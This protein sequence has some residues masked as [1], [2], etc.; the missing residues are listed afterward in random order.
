MN[1]G[2]V[3][4]SFLGCTENGGR[5]TDT[6]ISPSKSAWDPACVVF[7]DM[8]DCY[9]GVQHS[10]V[11]EV[12]V[13]EAA[14]V[15]STSPE[16]PSH[17]EYLALVTACNEVLLLEARGAA[18]EVGH[19][20]VRRTTRL[21][22]QGHMVQSL[23]ESEAYIAPR[24]LAHVTSVKERD[25][26]HQAEQLECSLLGCCAVASHPTIP[27]LF[28]TGGL[29]STAR[30][31][32]CS[33]AGMVAIYVV[34]SG[35]ETI[36]AP[37]LRSKYHSRSA[38]GEGAE[39]ERVTAVAWSGKERLEHHIAVGMQSGTVHI[40]AFTQGR[41]LLRRLQIL[42]PFPNYSQALSDP[43]TRKA[44]HHAVTA[45]AVASSQ[46]RLRDAILSLK[47]T[48]DGRMLAAGSAAGHVYIWSLSCA[49]NYS[50]GGQAIR[51]K[52]N[53]FG[54]PSDVQSYTSF[55]EAE[56]QPANPLERNADTCDRLAEAL[57]EEISE[58]K[59]ERGGSPTQAPSTYAEHVAVVAEHSISAIDWALFTDSYV[60]STYLRATTCNRHVI[61][62]QVSL[63][64][65]LSAAAGQ[66]DPELDS[67]SGRVTL[68]QVEAGSARVARLGDLRWETWTSPSGWTVQGLV[69]PTA[70]GVGSAG[71]GRRARPGGVDSGTRSSPAAGWAGLGAKSQQYKPGSQVVM[72]DCHGAGARDSMW[73]RD[74]AIA[75]D[76]DGTLRLARAPVLPGAQAWEARLVPELQWP[77][78]LRWH[79]GMAFSCDGRRVCVLLG[80]LVRVFALAPLGDVWHEDPAVRAQRRADMLVCDA[81]REVCVS[82]VRMGLWMARA[83]L[84]LHGCPS[85]MPQERGVSCMPRATSN[86]RIALWGWQAFWTV[87]AKQLQDMLRL[88]VSRDAIRLR[89]KLSPKGRVV[90]VV[91]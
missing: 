30:V 82:H 39:R 80:G 8:L 73:V 47:Y 36:G 74:L 65:S 44:V 32:D 6:S 58:E 22:T 17:V 28:V 1:S 83:K 41:R 87:S 52:S 15:A 53:P 76:S 69:A 21:L 51:Q 70:G 7:A 64:A 90:Q 18:G 49:S 79:A 35:D 50:L 29:D 25:V 43:A 88:G 59:L 63:D 60:S 77:E 11:S 14:S 4:S 46:W 24:K 31:W 91:K 19:G 13:V 67:G 26:P 54:E 84:N 66:D 37:K 75:A 45:Q 71:P 23:E 57:G 68:D 40:V 20:G 2:G 89:K 3:K 81:D 38:K 33:T 27:S 10:T 86:G 34:E 72:V 85:G 16:Q 78:A 62:W 12:P 9:E 55:Y 48:V 61:V 42:R 56:E 5:D